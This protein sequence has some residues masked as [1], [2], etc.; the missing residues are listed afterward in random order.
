MVQCIG[1][2][3]IAKSGTGLIQNI[4]LKILKDNQYKIPIQNIEVPLAWPGAKVT[5]V[6]NFVALCCHFFG[7]EQSFE[8]T[9]EIARNNKKIIFFC[10]V[11]DPKD[12]IISA[13]NWIK[14][15]NYLLT[16]IK[17]FLPNMSREN[18][19]LLSEEEK[20]SL[21]IRSDEI[22]SQYERS[23]KFSSLKSVK[24][25]RFEDLIDNKKLFDIIIN[26]CQCL[27]IEDIDTKTIKEDILTGLYFGHKLV[28]NINGSGGTLFKGTRGAYKE[29]FSEEHYKLFKQSYFG[30][31]E[32]L[33]HYNYTD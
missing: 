24:I 33:R 4:V 19:I 23:I 28:N 17:P 8:T 27:G 5:F 10:T 30:H 12:V 26:I 32:S 22:R 6:N 2:N 14:N 25:Y 29:Y 3:T 21:L 16:S 7:T 31:Q 13:Y 9:Y 20:I 1:F 15:G 18:Y 11:R